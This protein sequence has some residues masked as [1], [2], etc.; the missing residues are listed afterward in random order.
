[1]TQIKKLYQQSL[2]IKL[3]SIILLV[4]LIASSLSTILYC[5]Y[6][7]QQY[8]TKFI[9]DT[10]QLAK[11]IGDNNDA[12]VELQQVNAA[13]QNL[14]D[15]LINNP[16]ILTGVIFDKEQRLFAYFNQKAVSLAKKDSIN[17]KKNILLDKEWQLSHADYIPKYTQNETNFSLIENHL[18]IYVSTFDEN[19]RINTVFLRSNLDSIQGRLTTYFVMFIVIVGSVVLLVFFLSV[20]LQR[21]ISKPILDLE[22]TAHN[23]S[24]KKDFSIRIQDQRHDEIGQLITAFNDMLSK[25]EEQNES[26]IHAKEVAESSANA[27][28]EFLANMS[29][30]IRTPINGVMGMADLLQDTPLDD[31][32][33]HLLKV[34]KGSADH[35]LVV[36]NDI[37]DVSKIESGKL[38]LETTKIDLFDLLNSIIE[39]HKIQT[40][41]KGLNALLDISKKVPQFVIGD[42][43]RLK[44]ILINLFSNAIKFTFEGSVIITVR[45]LEQSE[46]ES[47]LQFSVKDSGIGIPKDKIDQIFDS[48]T[49]ASNAT[50]RKFGGTGLGLSISKQLVELQGGEMF[51]ESKPNLGSTFYFNITFKNYLATKESQEQKVPFE[52]EN[53][54]EFDQSTKKVLLVE[55]NEVNQMLVLRLLKKWGYKTEVADNGL[56]AI[57]KLDEDH[58]DLILMDV[59]MP[60]MDGYTATKKIRSEFDEPIKSIP[61]IAMTASALKGEFERCKE[62]GMDDYISKPFKKDVLED[63]VK[64]LILSN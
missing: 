30:E 39:T 16:H 37:L 54:I 32:Q 4:S 14:S 10:Q 61:I 1:M 55:D 49:Q 5:T 50:T 52:E 41:E 22:K 35:L 59:H 6:D 33:K 64:T 34:L 51:V 46:N 29:H 12:S 17:Q 43:V 15:L 23:I 11:I 7:F 9:N 24:N 62:A 21:T 53:T 44:Q 27:K 13:Q 38:S 19:G 25:I 40:E 45:C 47:K 63:K 42:P 60:E 48:F 8:K 26:L 3:I 56:I 31:E 28:Q 2:R 18:D 36:I 57:E 20:P 58:F